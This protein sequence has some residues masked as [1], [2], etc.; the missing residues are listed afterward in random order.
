MPLKL[1]IA[2]VIAS[3]TLMIITTYFLR[4]GRIPEK[5]ALLWYA[6]TIII[7]ILILF[8]KLLPLLSNSLG[9]VVPAN[10][11]ML[12]L[13]ALLFLLVMALTIMIAGQ[14]KKT[15]LLIQ[16]VSLLRAELENKKRGD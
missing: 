8:P 11:I 7:L 13:I 14:K 4:K 3:I 16:E 1:T 2:M 12:S 10:M 5:Y 6:F 9:F 15:I